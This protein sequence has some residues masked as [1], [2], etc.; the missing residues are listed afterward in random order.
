MILAIAVLS[1]NAQTTKLGEVSS[2]INFDDYD[3]AIVETDTENIYKSSAYRAGQ[4]QIGKQIKL[5]FKTDALEEARAILGN[6]TT[7]IFKKIGNEIT[8]EDFLGLKF[9]A[10]EDGI[11]RFN[12]R[13]HADQVYD[14]I[15]KLMSRS[16]DEM[17]DVLD[18]FE[19]NY[20][21]YVSYR[22]WWNYE[23]DWI[24]GEF[25]E[26]ELDRI[27]D[28]E[29]VPDDI[30]KSFLNENQLVGVGD[31]VYLFYGLNMHVAV[32]KTDLAAIKKLEALPRD[33]DIRKI[34]SLI[35]KEPT[36]DTF[37]F[38]GGGGKGVY[39]Y[40]SY[41]N[42]NGDLGFETSITTE[43][44][45][46]E[47]GGRE[48]AVY[49][50]KIETND[51]GVQERSEYDDD[52]DGTLYINWGDGSPQEV[53][54]NY[55]GEF[56]THYYPETGEIYEP[57]TR[58]VFFITEEFSS[59]EIQ[60]TL[61]DGNIPGGFPVTFT[62]DLACTDDT[63]GYNWYDATSENLKLRYKLWHEQTPLTTRIGS[64]S[65]SYRKVGGNWKK[66][67]AEIKTSVSGIFRESDCT[68]REEKHAAHNANRK[69]IQKTKSKG[70]FK[71]YSVSN[72]E[73]NSYHRLIKNG[74]TIVRE[75]ELYPCN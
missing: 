37:T 16:T 2:V 41:F 21:D 27:Y 67:K 32:D 64:Y 3:V 73:I 7:V 33:G 51:Q 65:E 26:K 74:T 22:T 58:L 20:S 75:L 52:A 8:P 24:D 35:S 57:T 39:P 46:C 17:N 70:L 42:V 53:I 15:D 40:K 44:I 71:F 68:Y 10:V 54:E 38:I 31:K 55:A 9:P 34:S 13:D 28:K 61:A 56:I 12:S 62:T 63:N 59:N 14:Y 43:K 72:G 47:A 23:Y 25:T 4:L 29:F 48:L 11:M 50:D 30:I 5:Y 18:V 45:E 69:K 60:V 66:R 49:V 1:L 6:K 19:L 36:A